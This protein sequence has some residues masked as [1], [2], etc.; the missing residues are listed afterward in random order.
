MILN[1]VDFKNYLYCPREIF[2]K[3]VNLIETEPTVKMNAGYQL[4][5]RIEELEKKRTLIKY[6]IGNC[7]KKFNFKVYSKSEGIS[8][9]I[10]ML[11]ED[12]ESMYPVDFKMTESI[13]IDGYKLQLYAYSRALSSIYEKRCDL[14]FIYFITSNKILKVDFDEDLISN[15]IRIK[16]E[17]LNMIKSEKLP[18]PTNEREKCSGCEYINFCGDVI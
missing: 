1:P 5:K 14:G 12:E 15:Y 7:D 11:L 3:Y 18:D 8:G 17:I 6:G 2:Y 4:H 16:S 9:I 13:I 10:D